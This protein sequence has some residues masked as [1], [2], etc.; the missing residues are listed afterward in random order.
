MKQLDFNTLDQIAKSNL[1]LDLT[2]Q[3]LQN[4]QT[5]Q[6]PTVTGFLP[7]PVVLPVMENVYKRQAQIQEQHPPQ[8]PQTA[9]YYLAINNEQKGPFTSAQVKE[10]V[11]VGLIDDQV[12][13]WAPGFDNWT[14]ISNIKELNK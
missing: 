9:Q 6:V 2:Q 13:C 4:I 3:T 8:I 7:R 1:A 11:S 10:F 5:V 12:L 14:A